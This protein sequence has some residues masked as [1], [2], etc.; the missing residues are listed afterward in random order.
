MIL[1]AKHLIPK[2]YLGLTI[3]PFVL[4]K[5]RYLKYDEVLMNHEKIHLRQQL[6]LLVLP[7]YLFY[8]FEYII[9]FIQYKN[10]KLAY[11]NISFEREAYKNETNF[12][13]LKTR[14]FWHFLKYIRHD[15]IY[16]RK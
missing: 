15:E 12:G 10:W 13:Y 5:Y 9:R 7:F 4:L 14:K 11:K 2:G 3:F 6:E 16:F 8:A 1:I